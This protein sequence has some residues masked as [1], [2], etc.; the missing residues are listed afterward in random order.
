MAVSFYKYLRVLYQ[1]EMI[2]GE[3]V[4]NYECECFIQCDFSDLLEKEKP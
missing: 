1:P 4:L 3:F 2:K